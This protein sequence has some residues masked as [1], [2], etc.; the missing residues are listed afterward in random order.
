MANGVNKVIILGN[1]WRDPE[2]KFSGN[3][4]AVANISI[5]TTEKWKNAAG[6]PQEKTEWHRVVFFRK[7]AEIVGE[8]VAKGQQIYI[9]GKLQTR[10]WEKEG[11]KHYSTEIV[12]SEMQMLGK[13]SGDGE[14]RQRSPK[15]EGK[16]P[17]TA[18][19]EDFEDSDIP[20]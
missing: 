11:Q 14:G 5:A 19:A 17:G 20:F 10:E 18:Q 12:A 7:L 15:P 9:E 2:V 1:V 13:S 4:S 6:E 8:Y 3:G 16:K